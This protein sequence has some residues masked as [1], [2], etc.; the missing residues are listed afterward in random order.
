[1]MN[2]TWKLW[3]LVALVILSA[4]AVASA[5]SYKG[6][7]SIAPNRQLFVDCV[8]GTPGKPVLVILNG[9]TYTTKSWDAMMPGLMN[10]GFGILRYDARGQGQTLLKYLPVNYTI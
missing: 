1:M 8:Q 5:S 10:Q 2:K 4:S 9:L 7:V 6:F 3:T